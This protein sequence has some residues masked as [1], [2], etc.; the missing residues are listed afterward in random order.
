MSLCW[1]LDGVGVVFGVL[2][3]LGMT[4]GDAA[5]D[6]GDEGDADGDRSKGGLDRPSY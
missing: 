2:L 1:R 5:A 6:A 4:V 3:L